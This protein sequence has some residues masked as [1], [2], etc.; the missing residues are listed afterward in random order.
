ML[1]FPRKTA[2]LGLLVLLAACGRGGENQEPVA[3]DPPARDRTAARVR[4]VKTLLAEG[5]IGGAVEQLRRLA[6]DPAEAV[7]PGNVPA[8]TDDVLEQLILRGALGVA[9]SLLQR[10]GPFATRTARRQ[11]I[12]ANLQVLKGDTDGAMALFS[13]IDTDDPAVEVQVLH[14]LATLH[15]A[16]GEWEAAVDRAREGLDLDPERHPLRVLIARARTEQGRVDEALAALQQMP[17]SAAR[18]A[19]EAEIQLEV[20]DRPDTA[21]ALLLAA[22]EQVPRDPRLALL[23]ARALIA[24]GSPTLAAQVV[25]PLAGGLA[26]HPGSR[27]VLLEAWEAS[28]RAASADSLRRILD[29]ER[30]RDDVQRLRIEGLRLSRDGDLEGALEVFDRALERAP[31]D[32]ELHHDRGVVLARQK[33]W[34]AAQ[35]AFEAAARLRPDDVSI[36]VN[37]ARLFDRTGRAAARDSVL[38]IAEGLN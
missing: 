31:D 7:A 26:I 17:P 37:L 24:R 11:L 19:T 29:D 34:D 28:G 33:D 27:E 14:E 25:Q 2:L 4:M 23:H 18:W 8:W 35:R 32:G 12:S 1:R 38:A 30:T 20:F 10:T 36:L 21:V 15:M 9:D 5:Q 16:R 13:S 22:R 3:E 6:D